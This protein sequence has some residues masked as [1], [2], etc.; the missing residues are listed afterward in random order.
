[1]KTWPRRRK[2]PRPARVRVEGGDGPDVAVEEVLVV[3]VPEL[4]HLVAGA[5][6]AR[7]RAPSPGAPV[8][9]RL[10]LEVEVGDARD[11]LVHRGH[12][13]DVRDRVGPAV[14]PRDELR[15]EL[16][17]LADAVL[18]GVGRD[19]REVA[20]R[21]DG[22]DVRARGGSEV[23][24]ELIA[25]AVR[26]DPA[27]ALLAEDEGEAGDGRPRGRDQVLEDVAGADARE[28]VG[29]PDKEEVGP[30]RAPPG[31]GPT[32]RRVSSIETS[33]TMRKSVASGCDSFAVNPAA[34]SYLRSLWIV[35][36]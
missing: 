15:A 24:P 25:C 22:R 26:H 11:P 29:V 12:H 10:E 35:E 32:A 3:V 1:V 5:E 33:S 18:G 28:L 6:L 16:D 31:R 36:A 7:L 27:L 4:D 21:L 14:V 20:R 17:H 34:G 2:S 30:R 19:E 13:L 23:S 8:E 9:R